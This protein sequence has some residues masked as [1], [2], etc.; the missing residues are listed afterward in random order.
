MKIR[1]KASVLI[2]LLTTLSIS[3]ANEELAKDIKYISNDGVETTNQIICPNGN[4]AIVYIN[5]S[6]REIELE[7]HN[8]RE[9][10]GNVTLDYV[11]DRVC[12]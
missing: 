3:N 9:N 5:N 10:L 12:R 4:D 2:T 11:I 7:K 6:T 1:L 8:S